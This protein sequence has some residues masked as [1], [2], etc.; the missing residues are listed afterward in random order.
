M[1]ITGK[2]GTG[3]STLL[4]N[5]MSY[6]LESGRGFALIDP[7][8]DLS[9]NIAS[10]VPKNRTNDV[11][12]FDPLDPEFSPGLNIIADVS[13]PDMVSSFKNI[14]ADSLSIGTIAPNPH[15]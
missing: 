5:L 13:V 7:H 12:Y 3:K 11:I 15:K 8:G 1:Y 14:F 2:T 6:D 9:Q 4:L 10:I